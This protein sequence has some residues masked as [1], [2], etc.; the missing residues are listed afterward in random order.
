M[1]NKK[2]KKGKQ[3]EISS[4]FSAKK[5][6]KVVDVIDDKKSSTKKL[7]IEK[8]KNKVANDLEKEYVIDL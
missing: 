2:A 4:F 5:E 8:N 7:K 3:T 1:K 6:E